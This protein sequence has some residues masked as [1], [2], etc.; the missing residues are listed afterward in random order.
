MIWIGE[1]ATPADRHQPRI[2][3]FG[4]DHP[5]HSS[6]SLLTC[7]WAWNGAPGRT[8]G[9]PHPGDDPLEWYAVIPHAGRRDVTTGCAVA[10]R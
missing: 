1:G 3:L 10:G 7:V 5:R 2:A 4:D 8:S 6:D 9:H